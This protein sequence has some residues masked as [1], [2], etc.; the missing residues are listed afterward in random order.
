MFGENSNLPI[1]QFT[2]SYFV[3]IFIPSFSGLTL[4]CSTILRALLFN[5]GNIEKVYFSFISFGIIAS[6]VLLLF[7]L[8]S[9]S[10]T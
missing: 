2:R 4:R 9:N 10:F 6:R 1:F 8:F 3:I 5:I 7:H